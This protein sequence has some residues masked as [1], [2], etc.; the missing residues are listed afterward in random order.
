MTKWNE[1]KSYFNKFQDLGILG[2]GNIVGAVILSSFWIFLASLLGPEDYGKV[3]YLIAIAN[4]VSIIAFLGAG[5]TITVYV[6]KGIKIQKTV[7]SITLISGLVTAVIIYL[8]LDQIEVSLYV[9]GYVIFGLVSHEL[10]GLKSFKNY[11]KFLVIQ[12]I[13]TVTLASILYFMIGIEGIILGYALAFFPFGYLLYK[14]FKKSDFDF[15][16]L[17]PRLNLMMNNYGKDLAKIF[18]RSIDKIIIFPIFGAVVLGN[19]QLGFQ[20]LMLLTIIP[21]I[22]YQYTLPR[23]SSGEKNNKL[24]FG[25]IVVSIILTVLVIL[26]GPTISNLIF[27]KFIDAMSIIHIMSLAIIPIS[28]SFIFN[29]KFFAMEKSKFVITGSLIFLVTQISL[30]FLLGNKYGIIGIAG[31]L[32]IAAILEAIFLTVVFK[33][34]IQNKI[35]T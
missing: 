11:S 4:I 14:G 30:I 13:L 33:F 8:I 9:I 24:Q 16:I 1:M 21:S 26:V 3:S 5:Q 17:K 35:N 28:I 31:S 2:V 15:S 18:S 12:R 27:P 19:Y 23:E 32:V 25:S 7:Y 22:V 20:V 34:K 10:I 6:A 29:S